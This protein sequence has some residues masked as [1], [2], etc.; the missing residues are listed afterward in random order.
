[1]AVNLYELINSYAG[2]NDIRFIITT[3]HSLFYNVL[4]NSFGNWEDNIK[5]LEKVQY[6]GYVLKK[7]EIFSY[8]MF[9]KNMLKNAIENGE[10]MK[11][12]WNLF[13]VLLEKTS[14]F[15]GSSSFKYCLDSENK[16][17]VA[18][19]LNLNSHGKTIDSETA[20]LTAHEEEIFTK[21]FNIFCEKFQL[22]QN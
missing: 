14:T 17:E 21:A 3:H 9:I 12:H 15:F 7:R 5:V 11:Y 19:L 6:N 1:M 10:L 2:K 20:N 16:E 4:S 22:E 8:Y 13:R 18:R